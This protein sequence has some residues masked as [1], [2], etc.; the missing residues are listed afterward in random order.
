MCPTVS[1][2]SPAPPFTTTLAPLLHKH[3][4][5]AEDLRDRRFGNVPHRQNEG[6]AVVQGHRRLY[7]L[8]VG[9]RLKK[10]LSLKG[11]GGLFFGGQRK[12]GEKKNKITG[13]LC[14]KVGVL[15]QPNQ[16]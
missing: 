6:P 5:K 12:S 7:E 2:Q 13:L 16:K 10:D 1:K 9:Q 14:M 8:G 3:R 11:M 15:G 4:P